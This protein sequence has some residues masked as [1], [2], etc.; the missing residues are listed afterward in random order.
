MI[1]LIIRKA[2]GKRT[3]EKIGIFFTIYM[4]LKNMISYA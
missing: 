4:T 1:F 2:G 3:I